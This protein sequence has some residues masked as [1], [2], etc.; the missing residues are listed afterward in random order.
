MEKDEFTASDIIRT[1]GIPQRRIT[2]WVDKGL[3]I[4]V[5]DSSG[6]GSR[7]VYSYLNLLEFALSA[8]LFSMDLSIHLVK[9]ILTDLR[10]DDDIRAWAE[11]YDNYFLKAAKRH[12]SWVKEQKK[13]NRHWGTFLFNDG[14]GE[15]INLWE[16]DIESTEVLNL[17]KKRL[18]PKIPTGILVYGF[19]K[20]G[21]NKKNIVPWGIENSLATIFLHEDVYTSKGLIVVN[22]GEIKKG[23]D[24]KLKK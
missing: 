7:R 12:I 10:K 16:M 3:V 18:K 17:V 23:L 13:K 14:T 21:S 1:L 4:P 19:K 24:K 9:R 15:P 6:A 8:S 2:N 22:L 11:D 20:D 5:V